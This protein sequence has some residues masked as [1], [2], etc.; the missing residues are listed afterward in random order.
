MGLALSKL[1]FIDPDVLFSYTTYKVVK[2]RDRYLGILY[3]S[4]VACIFVY[5]IYSIFAQELYLKKEVPV[6]GYIRTNV[7]LNV[8][9]NKELPTYC[10]TPP[11]LSNNTTFGGC[12]SWSPSQILYP[13]ST[14]SPHLL[15]TTRITTA[16]TPPL[17]CSPT[18]PTCSVPS[19][20][21]LV[22]SANTTLTTYYIP[23]IEH[24]SIQVDH[25][26]RV[27]FGTNIFGPGG[28]VVHGKQMKGKLL[29]GCGSAETE[30]TVIKEWDEEY[31]NDPTLPTRLDT[32]T[33]SDLLHA[34]NCN[35]T[36]MIDLDAQSHADGAK[37]KEPLRSSGMVISLPLVYR[38]RQ[39]FKHASLI[40]YRYI[41]A[42]IPGSEYKILQT[43]TNPD[44][45][46]T[47]MNRHGILL[48]FDQAGQIGHFNLMALLTALVAA[49]ALL[50][51]AT[52]LVETLMLWIMPLRKLY[53]KAKF[54]GTEDFS[55]VRERRD[56]EERLAWEER[57]R[58]VERMEGI[59]SNSNL[60]TKTV[61]VRM[62]HQ[63]A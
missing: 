11:P 29:S 40:K 7:Q 62:I 20:T 21:D 8:P 26:V 28:Q 41:P 12:L 24:L 23:H 51:V 6:A 48:S 31:R 34:A 1:R 30:Q 53:E 38:N 61:D 44:G 15:I 54:E 5:I 13:H 4:C 57:L 47:Y 39:N 9:G 27:H 55:D 36:K 45:S 16:T 3:Y 18:S 58:R 60:E 56:M 43:V 50:R 59:E 22:A 46:V 17:S 25:G 2:V 37:T 19:Y 49:T 52:I 10:S 63:K 42:M 32:F 14:P 35:D 33:V